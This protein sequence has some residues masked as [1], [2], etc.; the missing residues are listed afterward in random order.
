MDWSYA[1]LS[2]EEQTLFRRLAVFAGGWTLE[3][4]EAVCAGGRIGTPE[5]LELLTRL[6]DKSLVV[7]EEQADGTARYRLLETLRQYGRQ[8]LT[9]GGETEGMQ[10]AHAAHYV[11]MLAARHQRRDLATWVPRWERE[12]ANFRA[13][14]DWWE[15]RGDAQVLLEALGRWHHWQ[16][17]G[18]LEEGRQRLARALTAPG[19]GAP[20]AA[21]ADALY[22]AGA[23]AMW[24]ADYPAARAAAEE[25]LALDRA[26]GAD[27]FGAMYL[28]ARIEMEGGDLPA[29]R[30]RLEEGLREIPATRTSGHWLAWLGAV[31]L[32]QGELGA[33]R[34]RCEEALVRFREQAQGL[35]TPDLA[36]ALDKLTSVAYEQGDLVAAPRLL[37]GGP[38]D[39]AGDGR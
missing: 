31:L 32:R 39:P 33:A 13:A 17:N 27:L 30:R 19:A 29:A 20:T 24:Q 23:M 16:Y 34:A 9:A 25:R 6:V 7:V 18:H 1:L 8:K 26:W 22:A 37:A 11:A 2:D 35:P 15:E 21:R 14:L 5:V 10:Q 3:A 36:L 4:A 12:H 38:A 28:L